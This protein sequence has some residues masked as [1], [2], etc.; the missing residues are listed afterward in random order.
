M[1]TGL[2]EEDGMKKPLNAFLGEVFLG[3]FKGETGST[4]VWSEQVR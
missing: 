4:R 3:A 1:Y 2:R